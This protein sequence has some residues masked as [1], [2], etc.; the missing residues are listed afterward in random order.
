MVGIQV[1]HVPKL[2]Q[3]KDMFTYGIARRCIFCLKG[4]DE[5]KKRGRGGEARRKSEGEDEGRS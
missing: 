1:A 2:I 3:P 5:E 4:E